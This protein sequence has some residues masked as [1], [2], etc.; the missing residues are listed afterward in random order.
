MPSSNEFSGTRVLLTQS[1]DYMGPPLAAR[2]REAGANVFEATGPLDDPSKL[3]DAIRM[4]PDPEVL[5]A[6]L[7]AGPSPAAVGEIQDEDWNKLFGVMVH[8]LMKLV[9][10]FAPGMLERGA[11]K[12]VAI[13]SAARLRGIPGTSAYCAAR[14]AQNAF[15]RAAG[16]ELAS[17]NVQFNAIAQNYVHNDDYYPES[18]VSTERFQKHLRRNV[19]L[20][21]LAKSSETADLA[22][23]LAS[24]QSNFIVGQV[25]PFAGG[26][27]TTT[28]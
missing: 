15:V 4:C 16:L 3:E 26:W 1:G 20:G 17:G 22:L 6:N 21:R 18:L 9:R 25:V 10:A 24:N 5:L 28:G 11:G 13:T 8:P 7:A 23:F 27:V 12:I 19:P 14:G 2:F